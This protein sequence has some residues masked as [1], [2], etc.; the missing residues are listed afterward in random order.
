VF[1][2]KNSI[3]VPIVETYENKADQND[4]LKKFGEVRENFITL[5]RR[6]ELNVSKYPLIKLKSKY[7]QLAIPTNKT[8]SSSYINP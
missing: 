4:I 3:T 7:D 2:K 8:K 6:L 5:F 1:L